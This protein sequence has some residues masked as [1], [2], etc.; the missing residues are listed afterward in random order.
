MG[1]ATMTRP[2]SFHGRKYPEG[3][4]FRMITCV[5]MLVA[6]TLTVSARA[7]VTLAPY[8][9]KLFSYGRILDRNGDGSFIVVDYQEMR[10][11]NRRDSVP[12]MRVRRAFVDTSV[13]SEES[14]VTIETDGRRI[15]VDATGRLSDAR[16]AVIFV[17][18]R[19]GDRRLGSNDWTFGG[20]FNR[21][22]NLAVR[23]G[24]VYIAPSVRSFGEAGAADIAALVDYVSGQS[25]KAEIVVACASMGSFICW[26]LAGR[27]EVVRRL[28]GMIVMGGA[29]DPA[30]LS[31]PAFK[32]ALPL[33][34]T[35][36]SDDPVY[37]WRKQ[38]LVFDRI[39]KAMPHYPVRFVLFRTG[40][41]GTPVRMT[42]WRSALNWIFA[43]STVR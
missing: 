15:P 19:G 43:V 28:A 34:M 26:R 32:A 12:V 17:H 27:E 23:N 29:E 6:P 18:G 10:D 24:G 38:K 36:G 31:S 20:N 5:L 25:P 4:L 33:L 40:I 2:P 1:K 41:H 16:F 11:V 13:R 3:V 22:K 39:R 30:Y 42:D 8:K 14:T 37:P 21:M 9:D 7:W 35:H